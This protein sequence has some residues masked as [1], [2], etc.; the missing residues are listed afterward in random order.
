MVI[1]EGHVMV[2]LVCGSEQLDEAFVPHSF[3][4]L[5]I[6]LAIWFVELL[7]RNRF[8]G[9][10]LNLFHKMLAFP[11]ETRIDEFTA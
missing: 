1:A 3:D 8:V 11:F 7:G 4:A 6:L 9:N 2:K 10:S 5:T